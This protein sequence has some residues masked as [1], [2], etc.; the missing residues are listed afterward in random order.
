MDD[1]SQVIDEA[2]A[3]SKL[4]IID[5]PAAYTLDHPMFGVFRNS[6]IMEASTT[7]ALVPIMAVDSGTSGAVSALR[8]FMNFGFRFDR[9]IFRQWRFHG[10]PSRPDM[11]RLPNYPVWRAGFLSQL[12]LEFI[13]QEV[14]RV[15]NPALNHLPRLREI[16]VRERLPACGRV[17]L[18]DAIAH[19][20]KAQNAICHAI[21]SPISTRIS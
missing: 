12:A 14:R 19:L 9:G 13:H 10:D 16:Q 2:S 11:S 4:L 20:E 1:L 8:T 7:A 5:L 3:N 18:Q 17:A 21:L 6:G 15:G